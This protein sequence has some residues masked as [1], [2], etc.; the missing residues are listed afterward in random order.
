LQGNKAYFLLF[1]TIHDVL[2]AEKLLKQRGLAFELVPVP[3]NLGSDCGMS[4]Q[5]Y[6]ELDGILPYLGSL[7]VSK[8]FYFD[9][10]T[11]VAREDLACPA[12]S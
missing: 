3:R 5:F 6:G 9:G 11:Y 2:K 1:R 4:V 12:A 8:C 7:N 10:S